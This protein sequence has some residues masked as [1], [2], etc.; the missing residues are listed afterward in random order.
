MAVLAALVLATVTINIKKV[1]PQGWLF[2][3]DFKMFLEILG[4]KFIPYIDLSCLAIRATPGRPYKRVFWIL[5]LFPVFIS[6]VYQ[7][8]RH[9]AAPTL[10]CW[11]KA[12]RSPLQGGK[13]SVGA[14]SSSPFRNPE[15]VYSG[16]NFY[17]TIKKSVGAGLSSPFANPN[18]FILGI[19]EL[20]LFLLF[21][22]SDY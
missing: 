17:L 1:H 3:G 10:C 8:G 7:Y 6:S 9:R 20:V 11:A 22:S 12:S 14:C 15:S 4:Y 18:L 19:G 13:W 2:C 16:F 5:I 21:I